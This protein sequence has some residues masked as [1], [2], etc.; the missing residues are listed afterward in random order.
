MSMAGKKQAKYFCEN[1]GSE[2]AANARFCP[3]CGRFFSAVRCPSCGFMGSVMAF[4]NGCPKCHYAMTEEDI[5][6]PD[7]A[8]GSKS[9][10]KKHGE[11]RQK[12]GKK[13]ASEDVPVWL[14]I[15]SIIVL[16]G[17]VCFAIYASRGE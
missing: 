17:I 13:S 5:Y 3:A 1:C 12:G 4:K 10:K 14:M 7:G 2:V 11:Q 15:A 8:P 6:G 9:K 16:I